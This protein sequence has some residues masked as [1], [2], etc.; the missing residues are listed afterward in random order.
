VN[1]RRLRAHWDAWGRSDPLWAILTEP[2]RKGNRWTAEEF[3]ATGAAEVEA[4]L[5]YLDDV[6]P[7]TPRRRA[8]DFGCGVG[9]VTQ[10]LA[11]RFEE[12]VGVDIAP[13][14]IERA[15]AGNRQPDRCRYLLNADDDL[16][17]FADDRFDLVYS[18][19]TLQHMEPR[20]AKRYI[21]EF[22]RVAAP[23]GVLL[24]QVTSG[25]APAPPE[26]RLLPRLKATVRRRT[27]PA[28][29]K[30]YEEVKH[31]FSRGPRM[32]GHSVP[33]E[34][35]E[36]VLAGAGATV[37]DVTPD[38]SAGPAWLAFRYCATKR[39]SARPGVEP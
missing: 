7:G 26:E 11:G 34:E 25:R 27:P 38:R 10:A 6:A 39:R 32:E 30:L 8:L 12:V 35:V 2:G 24:F 18:N 28:V 19:I 16:R 36:A 37:L 3:F 29:L 21:A 20:Y 17:I 1:L 14:M 13:S 9:R 31:A 15:R 33:R 5:A 22:V 4:V 23:S